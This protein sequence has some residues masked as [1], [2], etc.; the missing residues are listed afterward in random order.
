L[1]DLD[2]PLLPRGPHGILQSQ[3]L[4]LAARSVRGRVGGS[5][6]SAFI[7]GLDL[8]RP[9]AP[10]RFRAR[11]GAPGTKHRRRSAGAAPVSC[12]LNR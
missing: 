11:P 5:R 6:R 4:L 12:P 2:A 3:P 1:P 7:S 9:R 8:T 10:R